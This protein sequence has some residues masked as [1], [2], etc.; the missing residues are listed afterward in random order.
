MTT[1]GLGPHEHEDDHSS[2]HAETPPGPIDWGAWLVSAVGV[3]AGLLVA[4]TLFV[5]NA[6]G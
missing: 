5:T 4:L 2:D 6:Q 1:G 3:G